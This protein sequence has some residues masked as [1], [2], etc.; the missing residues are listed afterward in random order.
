MKSQLYCLLFCCFAALLPAEDLLYKKATAWRVA[1]GCKF[2]EGPAVS[3]AW[4][5]LFL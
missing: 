2:T 5:A 3:P 4:R 1:D